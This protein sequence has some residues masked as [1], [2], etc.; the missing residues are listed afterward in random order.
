[1]IA[2]RLQVKRYWGWS[3]DDLWTIIWRPPHEPCIE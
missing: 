3:S 2:I 1:M